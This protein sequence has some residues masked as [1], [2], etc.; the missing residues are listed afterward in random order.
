MTL[1][2][3]KIL[4]KK[5]SEQGKI[6]W[7]GQAWQCIGRTGGLARLEMSLEE[8]SSVSGPAQADSGVIVTLLLG[9][10]STT[11][12]LEGLSWMGS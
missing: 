2:E 11:I 3:R 7:S 10:L 6:L 8:P 4:N 12:S 9:K 1:E 5:R